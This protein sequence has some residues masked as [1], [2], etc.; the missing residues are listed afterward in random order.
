MLLCRCV[1][2]KLVC[3]LDLQPYGVAH[4]CG[5]H[6]I[7]LGTTFPTPVDGTV[8]A[9]LHVV[10][11]R[12]TITPNELLDAM[13]LEGMPLACIVLPFDSIPYCPIHNICIIANTFAVGNARPFG[14]RDWQKQL[15]EEYGIT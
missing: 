6:V 2:I 7:I 11:N 5:N 9:P 13:I 8:A 14:C 3:T 15:V 1:K 10:A 12:D 4:G